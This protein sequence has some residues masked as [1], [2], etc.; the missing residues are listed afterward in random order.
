M[1]ITVLRSFS[2][3]NVSDTKLLVNLTSSLV[4]NDN[5]KYVLDVKKGSERIARLKTPPN[6]VGSGVF[7]VSEIIQNDLTYDADLLTSITASTSTAADTYTFQV[8]EEYGDPP[9][10]NLGST[11]NKVVF[12]GSWEPKTNN[13][14]N[15]GASEFRANGFVGNSPSA[16]FDDIRGAVL[17]D[18]PYNRIY[19]QYPYTLGSGSAEKIG[20]EDNATLS[21]IGSDFIKGVLFLND[22][23]Y[24]ISG[25][26]D[27]IITIPSGPKNLSEY[28]NEIAVAFAS[29]FDY[30]SVVIQTQVG[31][32]YY[33]SIQLYVNEEICNSSTGSLS[34]PPHLPYTEASGW[35]SIP[36]IPN[37]PEHNMGFGDGDSAIS[38]G[39]FNFGV[40]NF[41]AKD[42]YE[43]N[44]FTWSSIESISL[45]PEDTK[46][47]T[48][49][50]TTS[51]GIISYY[52]NTNPSGR[53]NEEW[54]GSSW[55]GLP[56]RTG[57]DAVAGIGTT[58]AGLVVGGDNDLAVTTD[59]QE[60]DGA[61][62]SAGPTIGE[63]KEDNFGGQFGTANA[64][65]IS[66]G[67]GFPTN[68]NK[69]TYEYN[70]VSWSVGGNLINSRA[71]N[72]GGG[73]SNAGT[74]F[75]KTGITGGS[76]GSQEYYNGSNWSQGPNMNHNYGGASMGDGSSQTNAIMAVENVAE[77]WDENYIGPVTSSF[78]SF[79]PNN[80]KIVE[81]DKTRLAFIN[82]YGQWDYYTTY[83]TPKR[84]TNVKRIN[85]SITN[86]DYSST[87]SVKNISDRNKKTLDTT[88]DN[89]FELTTDILLT[90]EADWLSQL[91]DSPSSFVY[92]NQEWLPIVVTNSSY[93]SK[94]NDRGQ[95]IFTYDIVFRFSKEHPP[96]DFPRDYPRPLPFYSCG[97]I[98]VTIDV[99]GVVTATAAN[100]GTV[101]DISPAGPFGPVFTPTIRTITVSTLVPSGY[102]N[103]GATLVCEENITQQV[104][105]G[106]WVCES[107]LT[108]ARELVASFGETSAAIVAGGFGN[109]PT[110]LNRV[111]EWNG[112][113]WSNVGG[114]NNKRFA[115]GGAGTATA[116]LVI[117]GY[118]DYGPPPGDIISDRVEEYDGVSWTNVATLNNPV[119]YNKA[120]GTATDAISFGGANTANVTSGVTRG[121]EAYNGISWSTTGNMPLAKYNHAGS[122]VSA[123]YAIS[124]GGI[125]D[126]GAESSIEYFDGGVWFLK[127]ATLLQPTTNLQSAGEYRDTSTGSPYDGAIFFGGV[128]GST[129]QQTSY[130]DGDVVSLSGNMLTARN[131]H[132][133][134][135]G[136]SDGALTAGGKNSSG[137][138]IASAESYYKSANRPIFSYDSASVSGFAVSSSGDVT[139][140]TVATGSLLTA[141][142]SSGYDS[143]SN[144]YPV[145]EF[146]TTRSVDLTISVPC[147]W[148]NSGS[149]VSGSEITVQLSESI[150]TY[151]DAEVG[152]FKVFG[153]TGDVFP[154]TSSIATIISRSYSAG[155][156]PVTQK[157]PIS[158]TS[159]VSR[160]VDVDV[161]VPDGY[162]NSGSTVSG[163]EITVQPEY[164]WAQNW[165]A[166]G[167]VNTARRSAMGTGT[168]TAT[169]FAGGVLSSNFGTNITE[170][171]D[172][173]S[174]S[175]GP[176]LTKI[177]FQGSMTGTQTSALIAGG[178][179]PSGANGT[180]EAIEYDGIS[181]STSTNMTYARLELQGMGTNSSTAYRFGGRAFVGGTW[182]NYDYNEYW[183][184]TSWATKAAMSINRRNFGSSDYGPFLGIVY[185]DGAGG[186]SAE[187]YSFFTDS[188]TAENNMLSS[189]NGMGSNGGN[190]TNVLAYGGGSGVTTTQ[191]YS[192]NWELRDSMNQGRKLFGSA[193]RNFT[194]GN[195]VA[196]A[197]SG[198]DSS[199][200]YLISTEEYS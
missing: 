71:Y 128:S 165:T 72:R 62:W 158:Y 33:N 140:P 78:F 84:T 162:F 89:V 96:I 92:H 4:G 1:A 41:N 18:K 36:V 69:K 38:T 20:L 131:D 10:V 3:P 154:P 170:E 75:G 152:G 26:G 90:E 113:T 8:G 145:V 37:T 130:F 163:T 5:F 40:P 81:N 172:G 139:N 103:S 11:F 30:Y 132:A 59:L 106:V 57:G 112:S 65:V 101:T 27:E 127:G 70:G 9:S 15:F 146:D 184:G 176:N 14:F 82:E 185:G 39:G 129:L 60:W 197:I 144:T 122:G 143:G 22:V 134:N 173:N 116:G 45:P 25:S 179:N 175:S 85:T 51:A 86:V 180:N 29:N 108:W 120:A 166:G 174:W 137:I 21:V 136:G 198:Q 151:A 73:T 159:D 23:Q 93:T 53:K 74:T 124:A 135:I 52:S 147:S 187:S 115:A 35:R 17:S 42:A 64:G 61:A 109:N 46:P 111:D 191:A 28:S 181:W 182:Q 193:G 67:S 19:S 118:S 125:G 68:Q 16:P 148:Y 66:G 2:S 100:G 77:V 34:L 194:G 83:T 58:S 141:S 190:N 133:G 24:F 160:S 142:Y 126:V 55:S 63:S 164:I 95:K 87:T 168:I 200:N 110:W 169:I 99:N 102:E 189:L 47:Q 98:S 56:N 80:G 79:P 76:I 161:S 156:D 150:F 97:N 119:F 94:T 188:W 114:L 183:N 149:S 117:G 178:S 91:L 153:Q 123:D 6:P 196:I 32:T 44:G 12:K 138:P 49:F 50:G 31:S 157:Y 192:G 121:T 104:P 186:T 88:T 7:D 155:Y 199:N 171:Y 54:N 177:W 107:P 48:G 43:W 13:S 105:H 195:D 167:N